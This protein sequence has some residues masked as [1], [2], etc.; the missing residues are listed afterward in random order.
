MNMNEQSGVKP[1]NLSQE[2][3]IIQ[4]HIF[5]GSGIG[6]GNVPDEEREKKIYQMKR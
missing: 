3:I 1:F 6:S 4:Q 2:T 5:T